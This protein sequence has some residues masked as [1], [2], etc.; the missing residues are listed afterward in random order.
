MYDN[1]TL[2]EASLLHNVYFYFDTRDSLLMVHTYFNLW[3]KSE[4]RTGVECFLHCGI[5]AFTLVTDLTTSSVAHHWVIDVIACHAGILLECSFGQANWCSGQQTG[6]KRVA[7]SQLQ[8]SDFQSDSMKWTWVAPDL[9]WIL[10]AFW[11][12]GVHMLKQTQWHERLQKQTFW[13]VRLT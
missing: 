6:E 3:K 10:E 1:I 13:K 7:G 12:W 9:V 2:T 11:Y 8:Q 5:A 4:C